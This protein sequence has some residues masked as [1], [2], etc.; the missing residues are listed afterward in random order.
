TRSN[1]S[2][3]RCAT[4]YTTPQKAVIAPVPGHRRAT[5][6]DLGNVNEDTVRKGGPLPTGVRGGTSH[7]PLL[8]PIEGRWGGI[9]EI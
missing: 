5:L 4:D 9:T 7:G 1:G 6:A 3:V 8:P 2:K